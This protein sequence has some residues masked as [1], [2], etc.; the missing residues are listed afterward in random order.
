LKPFEIALG[1]TER[2]MRGKEVMVNLK[3]LPMFNG[4]LFGN[5]AMNILCVYVTFY[6]Y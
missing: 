3:I 6:I 5:V 1:G 2:G 4:K